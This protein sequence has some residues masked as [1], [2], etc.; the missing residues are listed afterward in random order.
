[1]SFWLYAEKAFVFPVG[2]VAAGCLA[3]S[4]RA[5][6]RG[7]ADF[8]RFLG[9]AVVGVA[10]SVMLARMILNARLNHFGF[11]MMPLAVCF[12][13][14]WLV[15]E[16]PRPV[17]GQVR[18]N[19]LA[20]GAF[21]VVIALASLQLAWLSMDNY[22]QKTYELGEGRDHF[23]A[24]VPALNNNSWMLRTMLKAGRSVVP[25][26]KSLAVFP[27]GVAVNYHLRLRSPL[28]NLEVFPLAIT[29]T[30]AQRTLRELAA[31]PPD[32]VLLYAR[33]LSENG[34]LFFGA[35][36]ASGQD[37]I[38]WLRAHYKI[39]GVGGHSPYSF[40]HHGVD[41]LIPVDA[42]NPGIQTLSV[43]TN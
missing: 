36:K 4:C 5:A 33:D 35:D 24:Y 17:P 22:D 21:A 9:L 30:A 29:A 37:I 25:D 43:D 15:V 19:Y 2:L 18:A 31:D 38:Y 41:L 13:A 11:F 8:N 32:M 28:S 40:T 10:A 6:W 7:Q 39:V 27:G 34:A 1:M 20:P 42:P 14:H 12:G 16:W 23:Y 26:A 3:G